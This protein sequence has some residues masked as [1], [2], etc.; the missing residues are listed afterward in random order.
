MKKLLLPGAVCISVFAF[1]NSASAMVVN[2]AIPE[3]LPASL[4]QTAHLWRRLR[5][6]A[7]SVSTILSSPTGRLS[8]LAPSV[9]L[10]WS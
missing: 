9:T 5:Q 6:M 7:H 10:W 4:R 1:G 3:R 8:E 2:W